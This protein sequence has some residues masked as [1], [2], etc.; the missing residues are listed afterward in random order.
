MSDCLDPVKIF[1]LNNQ[2]DRQWDDESI[3]LPVTITDFQRF[4]SF[5]PVVHPALNSERKL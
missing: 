1:L 2:L 4:S 5:V 3:G